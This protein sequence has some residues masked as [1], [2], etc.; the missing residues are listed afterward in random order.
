MPRV[1]IRG[2]QRRVRVAAG[3]AADAAEKVNLGVADGKKLNRKSKTKPK[4]PPK[5]PPAWDVTLGSP[6]PDGRTAFRVYAHTKSEARAK[7]KQRAGLRRLPA[8]SIVT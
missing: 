2:K 8:G 5:V 7:A 6:S 4:K 3:E 1:R